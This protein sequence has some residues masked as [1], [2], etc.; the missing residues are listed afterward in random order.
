VGEVRLVGEARAVLK[1]PAIGQSL[2]TLA[3]N[4]GKSADGA[5]RH[6]VGIKL[7]ASPCAIVTAP[8]RA[9][10]ELPRLSLIVV[11]SIATAVEGVHDHV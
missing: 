5:R 6:E 7:R 4:G 3:F 2:E 1:G 9:C 8:E 10:N 11:S